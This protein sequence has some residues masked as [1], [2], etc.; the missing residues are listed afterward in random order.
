MSEMNK[1]EY[2][3]RYLKSKKQSVPAKPQKKAVKLTLS[4]ELATK[5]QQMSILAGLNQSCLSH[6]CE[7]ILEDHV[8]V[9]NTI[10]QELFREEGIVPR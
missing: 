8:K 4:I 10:I 5:L 9:N 1:Q 2:K 6:L 3:S 7:N